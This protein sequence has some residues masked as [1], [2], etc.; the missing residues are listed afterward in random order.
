MNPTKT[1]L[2]RASSNTAVIKPN[3]FDT[4]KTPAEV[5]ELDYAVT[6]RLMN[7]Q[8]GNTVPGYEFQSTAGTPIRIPLSVLLAAADG[9]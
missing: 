8:T 7:A 9:R 3:E 6:S 4:S 2:E 5:T 1:K